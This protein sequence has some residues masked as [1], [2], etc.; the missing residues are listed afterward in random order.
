[1]EVCCCAKGYTASALIV[2]SQPGQLRSR[3]HWTPDQSERSIRVRLQ[4]VE[5][6]AIVQIRYS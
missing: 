2:P 5:G 3:D 1:M 6:R 4:L